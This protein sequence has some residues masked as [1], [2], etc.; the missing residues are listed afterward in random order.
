M[1]LLPLFLNESSYLI[2]YSSLFYYMWFIISRLGEV[3]LQPPQLHT[4]VYTYVYTRVDGRLNLILS[5]LIAT[6][7]DCRTECVLYTKI[8]FKTRKHY[9][10]FIIKIL[11]KLIFLIHEV[12]FSV[13]LWFI[14]WSLLNYNSR[15]P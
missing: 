13:R 15:P 8:I 2:K 7:A 3:R 14:I 11:I 10:P 9:I 5:I 4:Y 12:F 1:W 6:F